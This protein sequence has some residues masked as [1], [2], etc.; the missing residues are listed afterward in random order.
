MEILIAT[1]NPGKIKSYKRIFKE[2]GIE[3]LTLADLGIT[4]K[5]DE[6]ETTFKANAEAK[7][8]FYFNLSQMP[9]MAEDGGLEIDYLNGE[10]GVRSRRWLGYEASDQ[11][12]I[13]YLKERIKIIPQDK[14]QARFVAVSCLILSKDE[15]YFA[16]NSTEGYLSDE[17]KK[18]YQAGFPYRAFFVEKE[19][20]KYFMEMNK[21]EYNKNH[22]R[23]KNIDDLIK[24]IK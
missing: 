22:H 19:S 24:Y 9:T 23:R 10:P 13:D 12:L 4:D 2:Q 20:G 21:E 1:H 8:R 15:V 7:A 3:M 11:E 16:E 5:F 18:D 6:N 14:R 17:Y